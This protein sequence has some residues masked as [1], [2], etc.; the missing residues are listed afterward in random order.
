MHVLCIFFTC[1]CSAQ[2]NMFHM[3]RRSRN[4]LIII[5]ICLERHDKESCLLQGTLSSD[6]NEL[7]FSDFKINYNNLSE[8]FRKGTILI[9]CRVSRFFLS[10]SL[11]VPSSLPRVCVCVCAYV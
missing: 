1:T 5:I 6:K 4:T 10:F 8:L 11:H 9:R 3:E 7:L 2:L